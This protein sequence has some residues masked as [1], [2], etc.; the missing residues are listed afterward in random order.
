MVTRVEPRER[1]TQKSVSIRQRQREFI[2]FMEKENP[3]WSFNRLSQD[4]LDDQIAELAPQFLN[5]E[6]Q[7]NE[8]KIE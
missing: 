4:N 6:D 7:R 3:L 1:V 5:S 2:D 8:T